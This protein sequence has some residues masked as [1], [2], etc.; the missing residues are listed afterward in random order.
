MDINAGKVQFFC[1][2][3]LRVY[4]LYASPISW[5]KTYLAIIST[6]TQTVES[7]LCGKIVPDRSIIAKFTNNLTNAPRQLSLQGGDRA[8]IED[9]VEIISKAKETNSDDAD[10]QNLWTHIQ[11]TLEDRCSI[12]DGVKLTIEEIVSLLEQYK[13]IYFPSTSKGDIYCGITNDLDI[14]TRDHISKGE[15]S[16]ESHV[17]AINCANNGIASKVELEMSNRDFYIGKTKTE[18]NGTKNNS[19]IVYIAKK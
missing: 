13:M 11:Y 16:S 4:V 2:D 5:D 15:I 1:D 10:L 6:S 19:T 3:T 7:L 18:G 12:V 17:Y 8:I 14:R 9:C